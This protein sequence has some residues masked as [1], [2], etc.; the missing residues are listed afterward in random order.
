MDIHKFIWI[1][2]IHKS[3]YWCQNIRLSFGYQ[4]KL[5]MDIKTLNYKKMMQ[6]N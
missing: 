3:Y 4:L 2:D 6:K 5:I 1:M